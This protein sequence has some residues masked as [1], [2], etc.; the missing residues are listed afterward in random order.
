MEELLTK[1]SINKDVNRKSL[2]TYEGPFFIELLYVFGNYV[3]FITR[4]NPVARTRLFKIFIELA[5]NVS[6]Y[7]EEMHEVDEELKIGRGKLVLFETDKHY[8]FTTINYVK[9]SDGEILSER[10]NLINKSTQDEL[11]KLKREMRL[12]SPGEKFGA[13]IGLIQ[14]VI[15]SKNPLDYKI[16]AIDDNISLFYLTIKVDK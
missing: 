10:C 1:L 13:R 12:N 8:A 14:A 4:M 11:R 3:K 5:Q 9:K 7:S 16:E 15:L 2:F 6:N